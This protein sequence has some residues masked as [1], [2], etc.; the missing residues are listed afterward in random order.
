MSTSSAQLGQSTNSD[1]IGTTADDH[2]LAEWRRT[3]VSKMKLREAP[4]P[5][6]VKQ[7]K[8]IITIKPAVTYCEANPLCDL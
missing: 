5:S 7:H 1:R 4:P 8:R 6:W 2:Q 3:L